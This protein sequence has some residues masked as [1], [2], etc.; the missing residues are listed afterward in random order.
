MPLVPIVAATAF[1]AALAAWAVSRRVERDANSNA[2]DVAPDDSKRRLR[3]E[4]GVVLALGL[5]LIG[6]LMFDAFDRGTAFGRFDET[7]AR[8]GAES[9]TATSTAALDAIT[10]L[11]GT[12]FV[13]GATVATALFALAR[14]RSWWPAIYLTVV[15][16]GQ[17]LVNNGI[18]LVV[19]RERP[20]ISQLADW[21]GASFPSGHSAAAAA[22]FA[23]IAF[24]LMQGRSRQARVALIST[25]VA[26]AIAVAATRALLGVHWLTDI[27]AGLSV[28]WAW[29]LLVTTLMGDRVTE[30][31]EDRTESR[32]RV[33]T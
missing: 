2:A 3:V 23:G 30:T 24:V 14:T 16:A 33:N 9:A 20:A 7:V 27:V 29:F 13:T 22:A 21:S 28:G 11:G 12:R 4:A 18:K 17:A 10:S 31:F 25:S 5:V 8:F 26:V 32:E 15:S 6:G 1:S 19:Q